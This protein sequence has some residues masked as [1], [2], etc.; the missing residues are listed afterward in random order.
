[1]SDFFFSYFKDREKNFD[2]ND[3]T[4]VTREKDGEDILQKTL[5]SKELLQESIVCLV[6][7]Y[8]IV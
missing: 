1:L 4:R 6:S 3:D 5:N 8:P 2:N 7:S